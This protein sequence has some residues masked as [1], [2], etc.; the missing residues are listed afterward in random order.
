ML[1]DYKSG[2]MFESLKDTIP[3]TKCKWGGAIKQRQTIKSDQS[4]N[5][6]GS[7]NISKQLMAQ[8]QEITI[9]ELIPLEVM[10]YQKQQQQI[11]AGKGSRIPKKYHMAI[12][13]IKRRISALKN[14]A[15]AMIGEGYMEVHNK[16]QPTYKGRR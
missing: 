1:K 9:K 13:E 8:A 7:V 15:K 10:V 4:R 5:Y 14:E 2:L 11:L 16:P 6:G 3:A 12:N